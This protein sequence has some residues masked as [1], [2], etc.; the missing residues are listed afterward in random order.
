MLTPSKK[1]M[2]ALEAVLFIAQHSRQGPVSS[3]QLAQH[4]D[5][6]GR[7]LEHIMQRLVHDG[8]LRGLRGPR[9]GYVLGRERRRITLGHI[10]VV[11]QQESASGEV[12]DMYGSDLGRRIIAPLL[13]SA[14]TRFIEEMQTVSLE[15]LCCKAEQDCAE[16][17]VKVAASRQTNEDFTI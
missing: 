15:E 14:M 11:L 3:K 5:F 10:C 16:F 13:D 2:L 9:G 17:T 7:Y 8:V 1:T 12:D 4:L 6:P